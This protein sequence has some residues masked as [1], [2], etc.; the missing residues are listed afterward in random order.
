[1]WWESRQVGLRAARPPS[2]PWDVPQCRQ[3]P[4]CWSPVAHQPGHALLLYAASCKRKKRPQTKVYILIKPQH[5]PWNFLYWKNPSFDFYLLVLV[6]GR[7]TTTTKTQ[8]WSPAGRAV[9]SDWS[10]AVSAGLHTNKLFSYCLL[11]LSGSTF[12]RE[13]PILLLCSTPCRP[14]GGL[15]DLKEITNPHCIWRWKPVLP[16]GLVQCLWHLC[17]E[18]EGLSLSG[19]PCQD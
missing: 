10:K 15:K 9:L 13:P 17:S 12:W 6:F 2:L 18:S 5:L 14:V 19:L 8:V 11:N 3:I 4:A 1:M 7:T 16:S